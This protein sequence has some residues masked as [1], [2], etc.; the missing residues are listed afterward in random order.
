MNFNEK[1]TELRKSRGFSQ[2]ELGYKL[3]VTRQTV[4][5]WELGQTTP[6]MEKL[7]ELSKLFEISADELLGLETAGTKQEQVVILPRTMRYEYKS[8]RTF[9]GLP[10]VHINVGA[11]AYKAKGVVAVGVFAKGIVSLGI[12]S[13]GV[14]SLGVLSAGLVAVGTAALALV[15]IGAIAVGL[16]AIGGVAVGVLAIGGAALGIY[17]LGGAATAKDIAMGGYANAHIAI[18]ET[19]KGEFTWAAEKYGDLTAEELRNIKSTILNEYPK[20]Q[21]WILRIFVK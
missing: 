20:I 11:G 9:R 2:E 1:L 15:S 12:M 8:K 21:Q 7:I 19:V 14:V 10:L 17:A 5:K 13:C 6:E 3:D 4:S 18:G 16:L